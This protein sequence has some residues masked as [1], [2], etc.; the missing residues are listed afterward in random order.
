MHSDDLGEP[1]FAM[2]LDGR[3]IDAAM[4]T[5]QWDSSLRTDV[6]KR[7]FDFDEHSPGNQAEGGELYYRAMK[8]TAPGLK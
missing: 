7:V 5:S 1:H 8:L 6:T 2:E 3:W 4:S